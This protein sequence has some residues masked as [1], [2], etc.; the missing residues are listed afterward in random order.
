MPPER[1]SPPAL[2][3]VASRLRCP[4]CGAAFVDAKRALAC[5]GGHRFDVARQG[6]VGLLPPRRSAAPGDTAAMVAARET[7][8]GAGHYGPI[9]RSI[10]AAAPEHVTCVLD[11][12]AGTGYYLAALLAARPNAWGIAL[13][14]S[15]PALRR[16][17]R[18]HPRIA[19]VACDV[20]QQLPV[21]DGAADL[22]LNVF[23][24]RNGPEIARVLSARGTLIVVTPTPRHLH[25]LAPAMLGIE[26]G[27]SARL[28]AALAPHL[29]AESEHEVEFDMALGPADIQ[30]LLAMGPSAHHDLA[31]DPEPS[32]VTASVRV[33]TFRPSGS[34]PA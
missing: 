14:A 29:K 32:C 18:A 8:L 13:D 19:A 4:N 10:V 6:H 17:V 31:D 5:T 33:E 1:A 23:A 11:L 2:V 28:H 3:A 34:R 12:G 24:P 25:Q 27:K 9:A 22:V 15:R 7:F 20:W 21:A 26:A 16:A 30:A